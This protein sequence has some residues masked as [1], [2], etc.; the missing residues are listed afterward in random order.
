[1]M[2]QPPGGKDTGMGINQG[3]RIDLLYWI[4]PRSACEK[5]GD[6]PKNRPL[7]SPI[8]AERIRF[9]SVQA[10]QPPDRSEG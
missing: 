7:R 1:M 8:A 3:C 5:K 10:K 6:K 4:Q 9:R 2:R